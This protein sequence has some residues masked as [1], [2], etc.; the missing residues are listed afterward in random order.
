MCLPYFAE[1]G[2]HTPVGEIPPLTAKN[3]YGILFREIGYGPRCPR[4]WAARNTGKSGE[5]C[6][7]ESQGSSGEKNADA[8]PEADVAKYST[9]DRLAITEYRGYRH[10]A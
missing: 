10:W 1:Y 4:E 2:Q 7:G 5:G 3:F 9:G 6:V 8:L